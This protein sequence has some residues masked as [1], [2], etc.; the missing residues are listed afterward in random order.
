MYYIYILRSL[1]D[2]KFYIG[3]TDDLRR[4]FYEHQNGLSLATKSRRP[5]ELVYYEAY[6][7]EKDARAREKFFKTGWGR[8]YIKR[9]LNSYLR[10]NK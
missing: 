10:E 5:F 3:F 4:R 1:K 2:R 7:D 6:K 9:T 8:N